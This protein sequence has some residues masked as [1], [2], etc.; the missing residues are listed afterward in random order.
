MQT[1]IAQ[2]IALTT[3]A[4]A[5]NSGSAPTAVS[6]FYPSNSTFAFC[7]QVRFVDLEPAGGGWTETDYAE[8]PTAWFARLKNS[9][10][11]SLRLHYGSREPQNLG[12]RKVTD[13]MLVGF[14]GGGG[15]WLI[16]VATA[17]GSDYWEAR[18]EVGDQS[19]ADKKI[20]RVTYGRVERNR[21][22]LPS[23][24]SDTAAVKERLTQTLKVISAFARDQK[25]DGFASA[26]DR[27][28]AHLSS[29]DPSDGV[30][31]SDLAPRGALPPEASQ[32]LA[33]AQVAWV[34]GG[35]GSWNDLGFDGED[36][37]T[38]D[39]LSEELF[40]LLNEAIVV[41][42]NAGNSAERPKPWWKPWS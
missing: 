37:A 34:F 42:T 1:T 36:Q 12:G 16:E 31:H 26:F 6:D 2:A 33:A 27:A 24:T 25:V 9:N 10:A 35:M 13:R 39:R 4:N 18:W 30:Y 14:V 8:D 20:W 32:L 23:R 5:F 3:H 40:R 15:R 11:R 28:L 19:R 17:A 21:P 29:S 22:T 41:A 38:Y 7:E